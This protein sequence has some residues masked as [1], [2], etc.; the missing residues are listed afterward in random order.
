M[1]VG[2]D[3]RQSQAKNE[4]TVGRRVGSGSP[5]GREEQRTRER[6]LENARESASG[7]SNRA[8]CELRDGWDCSQPH[9]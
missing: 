1:D 4:R 2:T 6:R 8:G 7:R 9:C 3:V 5:V